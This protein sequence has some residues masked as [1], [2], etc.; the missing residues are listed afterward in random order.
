MPSDANVPKDRTKPLGTAHAILCAK[1]FVDGPFAIINADDFY[2][3][4]AYF[5]VANFLN[6]SKDENEGVMISYPFIAT[7]SNF[8]SVKRG[9]INLSE[10]GQY[11]TK[12]TECSITLKNDKAICTSLNTNE[13]FIVEKTHPVSM[14]LFGFK[15]NFMNMLE[16]DFKEFIH[17]DSGYLKDAEIFL[18]DTAK[19]N[20]SNGN[21]K[22]RNIVSEGIWAGLTYKEDLPELEKK[23]TTLISEGEYPTD[24]WK[25]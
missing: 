10:D 1:D 6:T 22:L 3:K 15:K 13:E 7:S 11:V 8:G 17:K 12:I 4:D 18:P 9:V 25:N 21:L 24:L 23:I 5:K 2:G 16:S 14:N 19:K 20:V